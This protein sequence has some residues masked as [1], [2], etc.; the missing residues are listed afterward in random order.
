MPHQSGVKTMKKSFLLDSGRVVRTAFCGYI[1]DKL[2]HQCYLVYLEGSAV[3]CWEGNS[4]EKAK[5]WVSANIQNKRKCNGGERNPLTKSQTALL[6]TIEL[7]T[8]SLEMPPTVKELADALSIK[9]SS[10]HELLKRLEDKGYIQRQ[11]RKARCLKII[12]TKE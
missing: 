7:L 4:L 1:I 3:A 12:R 11:P 10:V 2:D 9:P 8:Q 6:E 5:E